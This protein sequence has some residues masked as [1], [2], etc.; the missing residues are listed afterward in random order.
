LNLFFGGGGA[1]VV[2]SWDFGNV[3]LQAGFEHVAAAA[4]SL[5]FFLFSS[6]A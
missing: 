5:R 1:G 3:F 2:W 4:A 6:L